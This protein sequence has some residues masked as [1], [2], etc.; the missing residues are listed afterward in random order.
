MCRRKAKCAL[1]KARRQCAEAIE[2]FDAFEAA[3]DTVRGALECVDVASGE[4]HRPEHVEAL[5]AQAAGRIGELGTGECAKLARYLRNRAPGLVL[6][7]TQ[8]AAPA[9]GAGRA[10]VDAG[11]ALG[12]PVLVLGQG[13]RQATFPRS[14][15]G[16]VSSSARRLCGTARPPRPRE[17]VAARCRRG[18]AASAPPCLERHR[19]VQCG[20]APLS[21][22]PQ[23]RHPRA[24][25]TCSVPGSICARDAGDGTRGQAPTRV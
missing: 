6:A 21:L 10:V 15:A 7:Q 4:L 17:R 24:F 14:Q 8:R 22:R 2:R 16:A 12:M 20:T 19:G 13:A 9:R 11:G 3:M 18:G 5:I 25:S 1:R 23:R